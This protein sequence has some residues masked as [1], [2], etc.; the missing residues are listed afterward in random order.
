LPSPTI[1]PN[2]QAINIYITKDKDTKNIKRNKISLIETFSQTH[3]TQ[4]DSLLKNQIIR[5][6]KTMITN[7]FLKR[8]VIFNE[9]ARKQSTWQ[10]NLNPTGFIPHHELPPSNFN[11]NVVIKH[12]QNNQMQSTSTFKSN[13]DKR[14][15]KLQ[16][17]K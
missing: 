11:H 7:G 14:F 13:K 1:F 2:P 10:K 17:E 4:P 6:E 12:E 15:E 9:S 3:R 5:F 16:K 8:N